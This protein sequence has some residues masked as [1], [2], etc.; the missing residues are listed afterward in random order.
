V[1]ATTAPLAAA[2]TPAQ[3]AVPGA[4]VAEVGP[5]DEEL[6]VAPFATAAASAVESARATAAAPPR[7]DVDP[8]GTPG[9]GRTAPVALPAPRPVT[10]VAPDA[11]APAVPATPRPVVAPAP[12]PPAVPRL[13]EGADLAAA[14][15]G[16]LSALGAQD[17]APVP[18][19]DAP[20]PVPTTGAADP[21]IVSQER[22]SAGQSI[23]DEGRAA[24]TA[25]AAPQGEDDLYPVRAPVPVVAEGGPPA[26][27]APVESEATPAAAAP[28]TATAA[29]GGA[30]PALAEARRRWGAALAPELAAERER[31]ARTAAGHAADDA[32]ERTRAQASVERE[33]ATGRAEQD[34]LRADARADVERERAATGAAVAGHA[35][36]GRAEVATLAADAARGVE[37][38]R[39][40]GEERAAT[41]LRSGHE[42]AVRI[43]ADTAAAARAEQQRAE[44]E[45]TSWLGQAASWVRG[46]LDRVRSAVAGLWSRARAAVVGVLDRAR[47]LA[48]RAVAAAV[49]AI[50]AALRALATAVLSAVRAVA[51]L[52]AAALTRAF[53]AIARALAAAFRAIQR[54]LSRLLSWVR[55]A[56][57]RLWAALKRLYA[58]LAAAFRALLARLRALLR[59]ILRPIRVVIGPIQVF[60]RIPFSGFPLGHFSTGDIPV[61]VQP[62]ITDIGVFVVFV[63]MRTDADAAFTGGGVGPGTIERLELLVDPLAARYKASGVVS[64]AADASAAL[65]LTGSYT[66]GASW[67][68]LAG[69]AVEGGPQIP[70]S[71]TAKGA[72][73]ASGELEYDR[74]TVTLTRATDAELCLVPAASVNAYLRIKAFTGLPFGDRDGDPGRG[75]NAKCGPSCAACVVDPGTPGP[76]RDKTGDAYEE[77]VLLEHWWNLENYRTE[78]CWRWRL[79][80][81]GGGGPGGGGVSVAGRLDS[82]GAPAL[83]TELHRAAAG[84]SVP[85]PAGRAAAAAYVPPS[86]TPTACGD[87]CEAATPR[88]TV[89]VKRKRSRKRLPKEVE[90]K[91][92]RAKHT[93]N[94]KCTGGS[95]K[96]D[97]AYL[98]SVV[99][100][101]PNRFGKCLAAWII[102]VR[103]KNR[104]YGGQLGVDTAKQSYYEDIVRETINH[105]VEKPEGFYYDYG[106]I[107]GVE[108]DNGTVTTIA[109]VDDVYENKAHV[110]PVAS[111]P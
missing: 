30:D 6:V 36:A 3:P 18:A 71:L 89:E 7:F 100:Q 32:A 14:T 108:V 98:A 111:M 63:T 94:I 16:A 9:A 56:L 33:V 37:T 39:R 69:L 90:Y 55:S 64:M 4:A 35:A 85:T 50:T 109:R 86:P 103:D 57:S 34:R 17:A 27:P 82:S 102:A 104:R 59:R 15:R 61:Y 11:P 91:D 95:G 24:A 52:V 70:M 26:G 106:N 40:D 2:P 110:I 68:G 38:A 19:P 58:T 81:S 29:P 41:E 92:N 78:R 22:A 31:L 45:S 93:Q 84:R 60:S 83:F 42:E 54:A 75:G 74:G 5:G 48:R 8:A 49:D 99:G 44:S 96:C 46:A 1:P 28:A 87:C 79:A 105:G 66:G 65:T 53:A 43:Q 88:G 25:L 77:I 23:D 51:R 20:P 97:V 76:G 80:L 107:V 47:D 10:V 12:V 21:A 13:T 101:D 72:V 62:I 73:R 67:M